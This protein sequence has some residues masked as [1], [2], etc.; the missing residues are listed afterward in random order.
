MNQTG[1]HALHALITSCLILMLHSPIVAQIKASYHFGIIGATGDTSVRIGEPVI[2]QYSKCYEITNGVPK[3]RAPQSGVFG[4][5]CF[6]AAPKIDLQVQAYPN[7]AINQLTIRSLVSYPERGQVRYRLIL[8]DITGNPIREIK[9]SLASINEGFTIPVY[10]L[11]MGYFIV[12]LFA[13]MEKI[14]S[15][16]I[17]K[18]S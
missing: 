17:L 2:I 5:S 16:K 13:D 12:T 1:K 3:F 4:I 6:E 14:Q 11:P 8:T 10:D 9:T 7:P 15:F 18:A